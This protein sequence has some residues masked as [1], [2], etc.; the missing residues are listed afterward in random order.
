M[1]E[2]SEYL[3]TVIPAKAD[4]VIDLILQTPCETIEWVYGR[5]ALDL[6][7]ATR[8]DEPPQTP[9]PS[10]AAAP[11]T[12]PYVG[13]GFSCQ[14]SS[15]CLGVLS[16]IG[17]TCQPRARALDDQCSSHIECPKE[18]WCIGRPRRCQPRF[19]GGMTCERNSDCA[20]SLVCRAEL[21]TRGN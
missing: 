14:Y 3:K 11:V 20:D 5:R 1:R 9:T 19:I 17:G 10:S 8:L 12:H 4:Q 15:Q 2:M 21:C 13:L 7:I 6:G 18:Q 16:C